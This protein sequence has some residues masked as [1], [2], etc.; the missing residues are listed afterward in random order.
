MSLDIFQP[1]SVHVASVV[2]NTDLPLGTSCSLEVYLGPSLGTKTVTSGK[3]SFTTPAANTNSS[4]ILCSVTMPATGGGLSEYI[5][6]YDG[7]GNVLITWV[8]VNTA[9]VFTG[10]ITVTW[11]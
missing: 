9:L 4:A 2:V 11:A 5:V 10:T 8:N 3:V 6:L 1:S 7:S